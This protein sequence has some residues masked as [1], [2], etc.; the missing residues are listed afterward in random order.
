MRS[1]IDDVGDQGDDAAAVAEPISSCS[2]WKKSGSAR[3]SNKQ[4][5]G[6]HAAIWRQSSLPMLPPAPVTRTV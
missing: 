6:S 2:I 1:V 3:S 5:A 4:A